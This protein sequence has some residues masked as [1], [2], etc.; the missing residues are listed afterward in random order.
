MTRIEP[1]TAQDILEKS[2]LSWEQFAEICQISA[3]TVSKYLSGDAHVVLGMSEYITAMLSDIDEAAHRFTPMKNVNI[4][5]LNQI[6]SGR[7]FSEDDWE[8]VEY[9]RA[10]NIDYFDHRFCTTNL[11]S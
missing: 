9:I 3:T 5:M 11:V 8:I 1:I 7:I 2:N 10:R 6:I 4:K